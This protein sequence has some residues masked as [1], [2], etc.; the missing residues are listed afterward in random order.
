MVNKINTS[1]K[2]LS[3]D[4]ENFHINKSSAN[5]DKVNLASQLTC[6]ERPSITPASQNG[7]KAKYAKR[8]PA[9]YLHCNS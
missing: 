7:T 8:R 4:K 1:V 6:K 3:Y 9:S 5:K 2:M